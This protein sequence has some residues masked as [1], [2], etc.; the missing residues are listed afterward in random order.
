MWYHIKALNCGNSFECSFGSFIGCH[1]N[2]SQEETKIREKLVIFL[3]CLILKCDIPQSKR[4]D[5]F[6]VSLCSQRCCCALSGPVNCHNTIFANTTVS[7]MVVMQS[8]CHC[9][10][11]VVH[12]YCTTTLALLS[13]SI[14]I[15]TFCILPTRY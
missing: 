2:R 8:L 5:V 6:A 1:G 11:I 13:N 10:F 9:S 3:I 7:F 12:R 4:S 15:N 14:V